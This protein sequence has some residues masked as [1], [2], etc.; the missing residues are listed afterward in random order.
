ME[1][2]FSRIIFNYT[3]MNTAANFG[4][5]GTPNRIK[6]SRATLGGRLFFIPSFRWR[7]RIALLSITRHGITRENILIMN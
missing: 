6:I 5:A 7:M 3:A 1:F 2:T 4:F